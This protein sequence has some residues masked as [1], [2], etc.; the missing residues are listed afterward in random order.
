VIL[1][2]YRFSG[3]LVPVASPRKRL[4]PGDLVTHNQWPDSLGLVVCVLPRLYGVLWS[5]TNETTRALDDELEA[6]RRGM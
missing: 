6:I 4:E 2:E 1:A 3:Q 5:R